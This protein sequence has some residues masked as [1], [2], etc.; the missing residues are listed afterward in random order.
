M[1]LVSAVVLASA[2]GAAA[3]SQ[4]LGD[5]ARAMRKEKRPPA[6]KVYTNDNLPTSASISVVGPPAA[7]AEEKAAAQPQ[8]EEEKPAQK[9]AKTAEP[10]APQGEQGWR[11]QISV[12]KKKISDLERDLDVLQREYKLQIANYYADAGT[13]LRDQKQWAEKDAKY[14]ADIAAKQKELDEAKAQLQD[15]EEQARKAGVPSSVSQ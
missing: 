8:A 9:E 15:L 2:M 4:S 6:K 12:Q 10:P 5:Y 1:L 11:D 14:Q 3:Q 13:Q 7:S